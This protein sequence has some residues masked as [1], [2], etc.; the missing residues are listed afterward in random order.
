MI[1][2]INIAVIGGD[3]R[4]KVCAKVLKEK[5]FVT[6]CYAVSG[7][8]GVPDLKKISDTADVVLLPLPYGDAVRINTP[9]DITLD[10]D[11]LFKALHAHTLVLA[12]KADTALYS[13]ARDYGIRVIDYLEREELNVLNA[14]PTAEGALELAIRETDITL[15]SSNT[16]IFGYGRIG[17]I[18][19]KYL[20]ALGARVY[21]GARRAADIAWISSMGYTPFDINKPREAVSRA[22]LIFNTVPKQLFDKEL[23]R[24]VPD[25]ALIVDLA[26]KPGGV[27]REDASALGKRVIWALSLPGKTA[28]VSAG[29]IIAKTVESILKE[30]GYI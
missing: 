15:H 28:P 1:R 12:G 5:G 29:K 3:K 4:Q 30:E 19:A 7:E 24:S 17:K 23:L 21:V 13:K 18:L 27:C 9:A 10:T 8:G 20:D 11:S 26:S 22:D 2:D 14:V 6:K 25:D 16:L